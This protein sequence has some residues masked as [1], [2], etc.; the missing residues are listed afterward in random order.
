MGVI[1]KKD[2]SNTKRCLWV[3]DDPHRRF[4]YEEYNLKQDGWVISWAASVQEATQL[5]CD[6]EFEAI[7]L[8]QMLPVITNGRVDIW[9][10]CLL[11]YWLRGKKPSPEAL[12]EV[13]Q[14]IW[15]QVVQAGPP[16]PTNQIVPAIILSAFH[17][18]EVLEK[19]KQAGLQDE[20]IPFLSKPVDLDALRH[21][22][23]KA[24]DEKN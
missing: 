8:D 18:Y 24:L 13:R 7:I 9:S 17:E 19:I 12:P 5:L 6:G 20:N 10:A 15:N 23:S 14:E 2:T 1:M 22:L 16:L 21:Y 4:V 3:D 11:L